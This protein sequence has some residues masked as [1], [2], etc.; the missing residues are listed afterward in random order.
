MCFGVD[1]GMIEIFIKSDQVLAHK[2]KKQK[3]NIF[4]NF[5]SPDFVLEPTNYSSFVYDL[6]DGIFKIILD[7]SFLFL[8][9]AFFLQPTE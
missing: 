4:M 1:A 6:K 8:Q 9:S 2:G 7:F 5:S 3:I